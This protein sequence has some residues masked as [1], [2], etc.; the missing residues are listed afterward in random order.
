MHKTKIVTAFLTYS[1]KILLLKRSQKVKTMKNLWAGI[2]GII[3]NDEKPL[4]RAII[5][6]FEEVGMKKSEVKLVKEGDVIMIESPQY[7]N[8]QWEVYPFLFSCN[9]KEIKLNWENSDAQWIDVDAINDFTTVPSLEKV[10]TRL[11]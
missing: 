8:H 7:E 6:I 1:E 9:H 10:L 2:S 11:L 4:N 5:E 3:E